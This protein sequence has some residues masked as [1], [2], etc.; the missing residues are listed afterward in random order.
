MR[1]LIF[2][3]FIVA[4]SAVGL[5]STLGDGWGLRLFMMCVGALVGTAAGGGLSRLG[6]GGRRVLRQDDTLRG[7]GT[8]PEDL[9]DNYWRDAGHPQFMKPP[10]PDNKQFGGSGGMAD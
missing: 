6:R 7:L 4:G 9:V 1:K 3:G 2:I 5:L 8:T 10:S